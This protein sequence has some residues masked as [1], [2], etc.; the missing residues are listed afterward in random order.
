MNTTTED[1]FSEA[2]NSIPINN[3]NT[4]ED[5]TMMQA[6]IGTFSDLS[7]QTE[8]MISIFEYLPLNNIALSC[9]LT[10]KAWNSMIRETQTLWRSVCLNEL[11]WPVSLST[12][13][14]LF[15]EELKAKI[16]KGEMDALSSPLPS[17]SKDDL[18]KSN[19]KRAIS[20]CGKSFMWKDLCFMLNQPA[21]LYMFSNT[22]ASKR[23]CTELY[24]EIMNESY[25]ILDD[26]FPDDKFIVLKNAKLID[27]ICTELLILQKQKVLTQ[28]MS[29]KLYDIF[30]PV[31]E[32]M[33][34]EPLSTD[35]I[36]LLRYRQIVLGKNKFSFLFTKKNFEDMQQVVQENIKGKYSLFGVYL[37][38]DDGH[39]FQEVTDQVKRAFNNDIDFDYCD[40]L[41]YKAH[42]NDETLLFETRDFDVAMEA[43]KTLSAIDLHCIL[44]LPEYDALQTIRRRFAINSEMLEFY[45]EFAPENA[46]S[47]FDKILKNSS[48]DEKF[49]VVLYRSMHSPGGMANILRSVFPSLSEQDCLGIYFTVATFGYCFIASGTFDQCKAIAEKLTKLFLNVMLKT[50]KQAILDETE[51]QEEEED[52]YIDEE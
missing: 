45:N 21:T 8:L 11:G 25:T 46:K 7:H 1:I 6:A 15:Q 28:I 47:N 31:L 23:D 24:N 3:N 32:K 51:E 37:L 2:T 18:T 5:E 14:V 35:S 12:D 27:C 44:T 30:I 36:Q 43:V 41:V 42:F 39:N 40:S 33:R 29:D 17:N 19:G 48:K 16:E 38:N 34:K 13:D 50:E 4:D 22:L 49:V 10:C 9:A 20:I 26:T 52:E